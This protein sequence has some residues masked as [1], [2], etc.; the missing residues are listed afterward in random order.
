LGVV[1][2]NRKQADL[3]EDV[4]ERRANED[5]AFSTALARERERTQDGEDM[6]FFV[7]NVENVQGDERDVIIFS[8]TF[9]RDSRGT[10]RRNFGVLGQSGGERRLNVAITRARSKV[11][12]VTS[13]PIHEVSDWL[14]TKR[15]PDRPR[16][17]LQAY[18]AYAAKLDAGDFAQVQ[19]LSDRLSPTPERRAG[20]RSQ[21][22]GVKDSVEAFVRQLGYQPVLQSHEGNVFSIDF[23]IEDPRTGLFGIGIECEAPQHPLLGRARAREV[24]RS[25]MLKR[26]LPAVHRVSS[27]DWYHRPQHERARL[28]SAIEFAMGSVAA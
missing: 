19:A 9:G 17:Y 27:Y 12:L 18:L 3:I 6:S 23:A 8:T 14:S 7:K 16:D 24:W 11:W 25:I 2:F 13:M 28:Q 22:D 1:T 20:G 10:F 21:G 26:T 5:A 4:L 15:P